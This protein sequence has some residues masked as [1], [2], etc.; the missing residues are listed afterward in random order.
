MTQ[1]PIPQEEE[2][3]VFDFASHRF[4]A[5]HYSLGRVIPFFPWDVLF[6]H[7]DMEGEYP[8]LLYTNE[9]AEQIFESLSEALSSLVL[10]PN[11][12]LS[13]SLDYTEATT[14]SGQEQLM[15][16][17]QIEWEDSSRWRDELSDIMEYDKLMPF[18]IEAVVR[19]IICEE[20]Y[21]QPL[22]PQLEE[23]TAM[24]EGEKYRVKTLCHLLSPYLDFKINGRAE[25]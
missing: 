16:V 23:Y 13:I 11:I 17:L 5:S 25:C 15:G 1:L 18:L 9:E 6:R 2:E 19:H 14:P 10:E 24:Q 21:G 4:N 22:T 7:L 8:A 12:E 3:E 20:G